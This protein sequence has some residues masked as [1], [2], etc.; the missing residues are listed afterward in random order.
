MLHINDTLERIGDPAIKTAV[1]A[2]AHYPP[3][4]EKL[5]DFYHPVNR[6]RPGSRRLAGGH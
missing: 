2:V 5:L 3:P 6:F 1:T 4:R